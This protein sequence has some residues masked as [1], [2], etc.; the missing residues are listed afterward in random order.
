MIKKVEELGIINQSLSYALGYLKV[1]EDDILVTVK[2]ISTN[3]LPKMAFPEDA[4]DELYYSES[5]YHES[6]YWD[7]PL[8]RDVTRYDEEFV[9]AE[10]NIYGIDL[11]HLTL[12]I[13]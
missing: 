6:F 9:L 10:N 4:F 2:S 5:E 13:N 8:V 7:Y 11:R 1:L 3:G 12:W